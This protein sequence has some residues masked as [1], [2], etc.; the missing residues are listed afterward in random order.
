M[1]WFRPIFDAGHREMDGDFL[2][3]QDRFASFLALLE[4]NNQVLTVIADMEEKAQGDHLFDANYIRASV[5]DIRSGVVEIVERMIALGGEVYVPLRE[6]FAAIDADVE[7]LL[8]G[9]RPIPTDDYTIPFDALGRDRA[10]SVGGKNA[11]L[12]EMKNR[13][14]LPVPD[15]FA[16][17]A[18][19]YKRFIDAN[20]LQARITACI[21]S[22][23]I[24]RFD[25]L[26]RVSDE[27]RAMI[28][29]SPVP[30]DVALA[31]RRSY[32][33][34]VERAGPRSVSLRSSALGEDTLFSFAGQYGSFLNVRAEDLLDCYRAVLASKFTPQAIYYFLSHDLS[35]SELGMSVSCVSMVDAAASGVV[36][37]RDPV[38]P[39]GDDAL[40][41]AILGLGKYLVDGTL[42]PDLFRVSRTTGEVRAAHLAAKPVRLVLRPDGG[43]H[44]EPVPP[45]DQDAASVG[46][47]VLAELAR[48]AVAIEAHYR[49]PQDIEWAVDHDGRLFLLQTRP[50]RVVRARTSAAL[51]DLAGCDALRRG[52]ITVSPGAGTGAVHHARSTDD[53]ADVPFGAVLVAPTPFPG[54]IAVMDRV[55][56]LITEVGGVASHMATLARECRI[57]TLAGVEGA[58]ALTAGEVVTV[59]ATGA[60]V[61]RGAVPGLV[62]ARKPENDLFEDT[63]IFD[64]LD[65]VLERVA[66]L[67][68]LHP[69]DPGF[70]AERCQTYH[71][72]TR[73]AHQRAMEEMFSKAKTLEHK[74]RLGVKLESPIP[75]DVYVL[76]IDRDVPASGDRRTVREDEI[77]SEPMKAFWAG[78]KQEG[79]VSH[80]LPAGGGG[81]M[82]VLATHLSS[83]Q[84]DAF[85]ESSFA[86]LSREYMV[87]SLRMG[88]H[89]TTIEAL[90]TP[91]SSKN[92]IRVQ[93]KGGG[94]SLDRR[95]RRVTLI[96]G[97]LSRLGFEHRG[98]GDFLDSA[99]SYLD[100]RTSL[101]TLTLVG[102]ITML[103]KQLDMA[104]SNDTIARWYQQDFAKKLGL[105]P[106]TGAPAAAGA[107][108]GAPDNPFS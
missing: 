15:G 3:L 33:D 67:N 78:V 85:S 11:Q 42:T 58:G 106:S 81:L 95:T 45:E 62:E 102:R 43:T 44:E 49:R 105:A 77:A 37:S 72:I 51:P 35:E 73:F 7:A 76:C 84:Q 55:N 24:K 103:T 91:E 23:D 19:A 75:L 10:G 63:A 69:S 57:P 70:S 47:T 26:Q 82:S 25:D 79:W 56:A 18:W 100:A 21:H 97:L 66:S 88:Y 13:L 89:F 9:K 83:T 71:D 59:D 65:R 38:R 28:A 29:A 22:V 68:L 60:V 40:V 12:G 92:Y 8:Q 2:A 52:G 14:G 34:L 36:Y 48:H 64:L 30:A 17:T 53:L 6:R 104:L 5:A 74:E 86:I 101:E 96:V 41:S 108:S 98:K 94:A 99:V 27:I 32:A 80:A 54:L 4:K 31:I 1:K 16:I 50:L 20:D 46:E 90:C 87:L 107:R 93:H 39:D 61:Y